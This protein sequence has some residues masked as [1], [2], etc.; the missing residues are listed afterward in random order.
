MKMV[1]EVDRP[2]REEVVCDDQRVGQVEQVEQAERGR[3]GP[4]QE[5]RVEQ[6]QP[7]LR[8]QS[9]TRFCKNMQ[10]SN[11]MSSKSSLPKFDE[12]A[13]STTPKGA[14]QTAR[15]APRTSSAKA[16]RKA[17]DRPTHGQ[18]VECQGVAPPR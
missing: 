1:M 10:V 15:P 6:Q 14:S 2:R 3:R 9:K 4:T 7:T 16:Q 17:A 12:A 8:L 11:K 18:I 13:T 5:Q